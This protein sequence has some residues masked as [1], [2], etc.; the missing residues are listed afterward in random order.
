MRGFSSHKTRSLDNNSDL[1]SN[2]K[3][4][5]QWI[6]FPSL[7]VWD[8]QDKT[9]SNWILGPELIPDAL[10]LCP[11]LHYQ[12][13]ETRSFIHIIIGLYPFFIFKM[14][15]FFV[16]VGACEYMFVWA[17]MYVCACG[18]QR[19]ALGV[20]LQ[21]PLLC[22]GFFFYMYVYGMCAWLYMCSREW[23]HMCICEYVYTCAHTRRPKVDIRVSSSIPFHLVYWARVFH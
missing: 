22:F 7:P 20:I 6:S 19:S 21:E 5:T 4:L 9:G 8:L 10:G 1:V 17:H 3:I 12:A 15:Y 11:A 13:C 23:G 14:S 2:L 16:F 18:G